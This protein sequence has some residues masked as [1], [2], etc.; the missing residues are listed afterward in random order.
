M[1]PDTVT[2]P[3]NL[4]EVL[5]GG[6]LDDLM[7]KVGELDLTNGKI[8]F[9]EELYADTDSTIEISATPGAADLPP[10]RNNLIRIDSTRVTVSGDTF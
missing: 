7:I 9:N 3:V 1:S 6:E 2:R 8:T 10:D 5:P 4:F